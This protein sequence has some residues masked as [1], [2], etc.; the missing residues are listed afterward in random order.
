MPLF[1]IRRNVPGMDQGEIDAAGYRAI[2]CAYEYPGMKWHRSYWDRQRGVLECL[3]ECQDEAEVRSHA[4]RSR[5]PCDDVREVVIIDPVAYT[6]EAGAE[7]AAR[8]R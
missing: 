8:S 3:Y 4:E 1:L 5:I 7:A 6:D 2:M